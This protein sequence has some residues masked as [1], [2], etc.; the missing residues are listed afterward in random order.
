MG[1]GWFGGGFL[2]SGL[3]V[4]FHLRL[5]LKRKPAKLVAC[6]ALASLATLGLGAR[7]ARA[8][9]YTE[10]VVYSFCGQGGSDCTDGFDPVGGVIQASDGNF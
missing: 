4:G 9:T 8:A 5:A 1:E 2:A 7:C 6:L 3:A 10:S